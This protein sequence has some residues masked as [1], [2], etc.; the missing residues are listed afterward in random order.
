MCRPG[1]TRRCRPADEARLVQGWQSS[2]S[3]SPLGADRRAGCRELWRSTGLASAALADGHVIGLQALAIEGGPRA[4][5]PL[6]RSLEFLDPPTVEASL[7]W[8]DFSPTGG[9]SYGWGTVTG[10]D[11]AGRRVT[12]DVVREPG[13]VAGLD[14]PVTAPAAAEPPVVATVVVG[15]TCSRPG[16]G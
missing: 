7:P 3:W 2:D 9:R 4:G 1:A 10:T 6:E 5:M 12:L 13:R 16:A 8:E 11:E 15:E 14:V